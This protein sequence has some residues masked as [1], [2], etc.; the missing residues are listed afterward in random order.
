MTQVY[1]P[2][3]AGSGSNVTEDG[4]RDMARHWLA[5]GVIAGEDNLAETYGDNSGMQVKTKTGKAWIRG[6][7][8][9][10]DAEVTSAIAAADPANPRIDRLIL[11][12]DF[13]GNTIAIAVLQGTAAAVPAAPALTQS[14]SVWEI[15]LARV[16]VGAGVG[17][18][19]AAN[20][21]DER[22][23]VENFNVGSL[24]MSGHLINEI[25][26]W[27]PIVA[28]GDL[29]AL[30]LWWDK[31]GTP[32]TAP[33]IQDLSA[34][35]LTDTYETG[36]KVTADAASEGLAQRWT[37]SEEPRVKAGRRFS[38]LFAIWPV[39]G[40]GVTLK[41]VNSDATETAAVAVTAAQWNIVEVP[42]HLL[43]GTYCEV[44]AIASAAGTFYV[45]PLGVNIGTRAYPL[46]PRPTRFVDTYVNV[47]NGADAGGAYTDVDLTAN[48]SPLC[49]AAQLTGNYR[50][51]TTLDSALT[52]RRN[53]STIPHQVV[54]AGHLGI[55]LSGSLP[56]LL[57][58]GQIFEYIGGAAGDSEVIYMYLD[59]YWE[60]A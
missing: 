1:R 45:V 4:W 59:G 14:T 58:D 25:K 34:A 54:I 31:V 32:T 18:I 26:G 17:S 16:A 42:N 43:A 15:S 53:G 11:R 56:I 23:F 44:R 49:Y 51:N 39:G 22:L 33:T 50:N 28:S 40:I 52:V 57:D 7:Y 41:L 48:T 20:V 3:D 47:V 30:N 19:L 8:W 2:F 29:D 12:A 5:T 13:V 60:W 27:P 24:R 46:A 35:G 9:A 55:Y 38:A 6:H 21:T 10:S 36:L 37:Y